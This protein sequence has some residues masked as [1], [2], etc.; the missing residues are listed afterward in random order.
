M[1]EINVNWNI[2]TIILDIRLRREI[3]FNKQINIIQS[4]NESEIY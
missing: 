1:P 4:S 2:F 3:L